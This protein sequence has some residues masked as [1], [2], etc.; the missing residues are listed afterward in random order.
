MAKSKFASKPKVGVKGTLPAP[1]DKAKPVSKP[2]PIR[3]TIEQIVFAFVLAFLF[4]T[5]EAEAFVIPTGSMA[6]TLMGRHKDVICPKCKFAYSASASSETDEG[7][8]LGR[9]LTPEEL[10][11]RQVV[12]VTCPMCRFSLNVDQTNPEGSRHPSYNG[13]RILVAKFPYDFRDP[14]RW[15]VVV[16]KFPGDAK[17]N[18]IKRLV[19]LPG[20][21]VR[22]QHGDILTRAAGDED[23]K[24]V[25]KDPAKMRAMLQLVYDNNYI[26][27][28]MTQAGW[29]RRW[30]TWPAADGTLPDWQS[31]DGG[32]S[33]KLEREP[34]G[35]AWLRY[36]NFVPLAPDWHYIQQGALPKDVHVLPQLITDF[37]AYNMF[38]AKRQDVDA[39]T[40]LHWV[41]D[42]MVEADVDVNSDTGELLIDL[43]KGGRH[44][45][46]RMDVATGKATLTVDG[47][48]SF[49]PTADTGIKGPGKHTVGL[50]NVDQE[51]TLWVDGK[52]VKFNTPTTY[53]PLGNDYPQSSDKDLGDLAPAGIGAKS[54]KISVENL[55]LWRDIYYIADK[56]QGGGGDRIIEYDRRSPLLQMNQGELANFMSSPSEWETL[57]PGQVNASQEVIFPLEADQF[58]V[59]GDNSP[60]SKDSRLWDEHEQFVSRELLTGKAIFIYWPHS[61][62]EIPG[63]HIPFPFFPNFASMGFVR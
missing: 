7:A 1:P 59:L 57:R 9:R 15:D 10:Q 63:V 8:P 18:Y 42:L 39:S 44:F 29:P 38:K 62:G 16:F 11:D 32:R 24:I 13:D 17:T 40:G 47:L 23:F 48:K 55:R 54:A 36:Q 41:G 19:G 27:D 6:P 60:Q 52:V 26:V 34:N 51:L 25:R 21:T 30:Q 12:A 49:R 31:T 43:V 50:A 3:E 28:Q 53:P 61:K 56:L 37:Y 20:E 33:Y 45:R 46:A 58:F 2:H 14:K 35:E 22:I 5:F 4:R